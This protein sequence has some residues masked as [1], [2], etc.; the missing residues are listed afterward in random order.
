MTYILAHAE[1]SGKGMLKNHSL[2][3]PEEKRRFLQRNLS[4]NKFS[5]IS[6]S[7]PEKGDKYFLSRT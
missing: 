5:L 2:V 6:L 1:I 3:I 4:V 7:D